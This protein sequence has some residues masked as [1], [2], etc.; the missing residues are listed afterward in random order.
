[1]TKSHR[2]PRKR[3]DDLLDHAVGEIFLLRI[4]A[5][6]GKRQYRDRRLVGQR[7][8]CLRR[9][10][11]HR[12][13]KAVAAAGDRLDAA[14]VRSPFIE[15]PPKRRDLHR[16]VA[17]LDDGSRP[18]RLPVSRPSRRGP[19]PLDQ[20]TE[21]LER[22]RADRDR[23]RKR[24][25]DLVGIGRTRSRRKPSN[26][27]TSAVAGASMR[28][29]PA[30]TSKARNEAWPSIRAIV[31]LTERFWNISNRFKR[32]N[33]GFIAWPPISAF[34]RC[35]GESLPGAIRDHKGRSKMKR[36]LSK[37][38][39]ASRDRAAGAERCRL[40]RRK[41]RFRVLECDPQ[42]RI[43]V[44][45][46]RLHASA[47]SDGS[48]PPP[49][50]VVTGIKVFDG[51]GNLTQRDYRGDNLADPTSRR[52]GRKPAPIRSIPTAPAAW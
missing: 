39:L 32:F 47:S 6:I 14:A 45:R 19:R 42:G 27:K 34:S 9:S 16:Q 30:A 48:P 7:E 4:A 28:V 43:R 3:G 33:P 22:A 38:T 5:Q 36:R 13:H 41:R 52:Q 20:R 31:P 26:R 21:N 15:D 10:P 11:R 8:P 40:G 37:G 24:R 49:T 17:P 51:H 29:P 1:M 2:D 18:H 25:S 12:R 23:N 46:Y 44:R 50:E 35:P